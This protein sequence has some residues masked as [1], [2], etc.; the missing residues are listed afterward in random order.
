MFDNQKLFYVFNNRKQGVLR[1]HFL[2]VLCYFHLFL[3]T[4]LRNNYI[5][6]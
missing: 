6:I 5:N 3:K 1:K 2:V 4:I